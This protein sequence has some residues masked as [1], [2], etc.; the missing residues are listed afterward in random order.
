MIDDYYTLENSNGDN[1]DH[2]TVK[3]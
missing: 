1:I 2:Q 3:Y